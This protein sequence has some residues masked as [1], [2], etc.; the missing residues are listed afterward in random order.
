M[1]V[2]GAVTVGADP[3]CRTVGGV[4]RVPVLLASV[5]ILALGACSSSGDE[6]AD[7]GAAA[8][9]S[10]GA[11]GE[12]TVASEPT[13][14]PTSEVPAAAEAASL[15]AAGST[16]ADT[17]EDAGATTAPG[18]SNGDT[19]AAGSADP[20]TELDES[21]DELGIGDGTGVVVID[22][23]R[24]TFDAEICAPEPGFVATGLGS[25]PEGETGFVEIYVDVGAD[26]DGDGEPDESGSVAVTVGKT[27]LLGE[28]VPD[29][30]LWLALL[31]SFGGLERQDFT[32]EI[33][34]GAISGEGEIGD[35]RGLAAPLGETVPFSFE[36][37]CG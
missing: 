12:A 3:R 37:S 5:A 22:G 36:A 20:A 18:A 34:D 21:L 14:E 7:R 28:D 31:Q 27:D 10:S 8:P 17:A 24:W 30:P 1:T 11:G 4:R 25:G 2:A 35:V 29:R 6:D 15:P 19:V 32:Y 26:L 16:P 13:T 33:D 23:A 9:A